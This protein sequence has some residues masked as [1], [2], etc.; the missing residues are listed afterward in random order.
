MLKRTHACTMTTPRSSWQ[1]G[2]ALRQKDEQGAT[3]WELD[4]IEERKVCVGQRGSAQNMCQNITRPEDCGSQIPA[5]TGRQKIR[6]QGNRNK[7]TALILNSIN[8]CTYK[9]IAKVNLYLQHQSTL[10]I[11][12][13]TVDFIQHFTQIVMLIT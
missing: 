3:V 12:A 7:Q 1:A 8:L 5:C 10:K 9:N 11:V 2:Q 4:R 6:K 13:Y